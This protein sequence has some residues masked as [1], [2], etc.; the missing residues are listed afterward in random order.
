M[1]QL[2]GVGHA[3]ISAGSFAEAVQGLGVLAVAI[4]SAIVAYLSLS[5]LRPR[6]SRI[7]RRWRARNM[8]GEP[9]I[10]GPSRGIPRGR[11]QPAEASRPGIGHVAFRQPRHDLG[12]VI[13]TLRIGIGM[14][15]RDLGRLVGCGP[16]TIASL[17]KG[18]PRVPAQVLVRALAAIGSRYDD[19]SPPQTDAP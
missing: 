5:R 2:T 7:R 6:R 1:E 10:A 14:S 15:R 8:R 18:C 12:L 4:G 17:E 16:G 9:R 13:K 19:S 3:L 11:K